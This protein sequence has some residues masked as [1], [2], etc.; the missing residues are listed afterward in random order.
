MGRV[1]SMTQVTQV[2]G[3]SSGRPES[4]VSDGFGTSRRPV[5]AISKTP[6]SFVEPKRFFAARSM[7]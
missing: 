5:S 1:P 7:R 3:V 4:M 6:I 2:P